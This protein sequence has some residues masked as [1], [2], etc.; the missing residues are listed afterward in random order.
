MSAPFISTKI[1]LGLDLSK[2]SGSTVSNTPTIKQ[3]SSALLSPS[4]FS[5]GDER[6]SPRPS[7]KSMSTIFDSHS[8]SPSSS[9]FP[10]GLDHQNSAGADTNSIL[11]HEI[12]SYPIASIE[13]K[14]VLQRRRSTKTSLRPV[15]GVVREPE[16][17]DGTRGFGRRRSSCLSTISSVDV[18]TTVG[19]IG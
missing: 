9:I 11:E 3:K 8:V 13:P 4:F 19:V 12:E 6:V 16:G 1:N 7:P 5:G 14:R 18:G 2:K 10:P 15:A 17:P